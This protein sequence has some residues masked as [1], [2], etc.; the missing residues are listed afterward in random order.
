MTIDN[1]TCDEETY[2]VTMAM[3]QSAI[4]VKKKPLSYSIL[5]NEK[6]QLLLRKQCRLNVEGEA[7]KKYEQRMKADSDN[8]Q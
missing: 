1:E 8:Y 2:D 6:W 7:M 5:K 3:K 4:D